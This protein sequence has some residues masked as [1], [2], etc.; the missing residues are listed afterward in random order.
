[1]TGAGLPA[2]A[3]A[4]R[5]EAASAGAPPDPPGADWDLSGFFPEPDGPA[6]RAFR[7]ALERDV[8]ALEAELAGLGPLTAASGPGWRD[9]LLRLEDV[10][11]RAAHLGSYLSCLSAS[12]ASDAG[13]RREVARLTG[14]RALLAKRY[15]RVRAALAAAP[16]AEFERWLGHPALAQARYFLTRLR[17]EASRR[18]PVE[19]EELAADLEVTAL[20]A[21]SRLYDQIT[22]TLCFD[23]EVPGEPARR[24][25]AS[26]ARSLLGDPRAEVR[27]A[28]LRGANRAF[29]ARADVFAA[30]WNAIVG[31]RLAL[32]RRRGVH[33]LEPALF[34]AGISRA[35]LD[36]LLSAVTERREIPRRYL[37][38]KAR[39]L[40]SDRLG[41]Q[42][43]EAPLPAAPAPPISFDAARE[44]VLAAFAGCDAGLAELAA[45]AFARRWIDWSPRPSKRPG[46]FCS[47]SP[48]LGESRI[49]MTFGGSAGDVSTLAHELGHAWHGHLTRE[50]RPWARRYPMTLAETASTF[51]E[52]ILQDA[53]LSDPD[54]GAAARLAVLD[55][56]LRDAA[57][58]LLNL[59]MRFAF[60]RRAYE[61][62]AAGE[63]SAER[64]CE[65]ICEAQREWY[66][67]ALAEGEL[68]AW[69]WASKLHFYIA[70]VSFYNFPYTVG[71][72]FSLGL[73]ARAR[74]EGPGFLPRAWELL[75]LAG[76]DDAPALARR[77]LGVELEQPAFWHASI[78]AVEA[79]LAR[80]EAAQDAAGP[81]GAPPAR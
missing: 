76:S 29:E 28:A 1:V 60:E 62:R 41:F 42:D 22:G 78:D 67:D 50:L 26:L 34:E 70:G 75:R 2:G 20:A 43:L 16:A 37:R 17:E 73:Y 12:D 30:C 77:C 45:R 64:L 47:T 3:R 65:A 36:A 15:A 25:P 18:M 27:Q 72:L 74:A 55:R 71:Y 52:Q 56:R 24:V 10:A 59:P 79:D 68:D 51:A 81:G 48:L 32:Y 8:D 4:G 44:R 57:A 54:A 40:G 13:A 9:A 33:F 49:F 66:G 39:L 7:D 80:F 35:T 19:L 5:P 38:R 6:Y 63:L 69:F 61:E 53:T 46:G 58:Y 23:L 14:L 31:T 21:W 11:G